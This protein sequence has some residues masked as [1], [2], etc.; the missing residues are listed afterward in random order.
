MFKPDCTTKVHYEDSSIYIYI[1][2]LRIFK[3]PAVC[4]VLNKN[5]ACVAERCFIRMKNSKQTHTHLQRHSVQLYNI[6]FIEFVSE[7]RFLSPR[8]FAYGAALNNG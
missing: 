4:D 2:S 3:Y 5:Y 1:Y 7:M 6:R 8:Q